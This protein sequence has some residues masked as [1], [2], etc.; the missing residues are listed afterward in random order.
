MVPNRCWTGAEME[1]NSADVA[2]GLD[3]LKSGVEA[4]ASAYKMVRD[5]KASCKQSPEQDKLVDAAIDEAGKAAKIA[6]AQ[7]AKAL[8]YELCRCEFPPHAMLT[9]GYRSMG[10]RT[11]AIYECTRCG[12]NTSGRYNF[13]RN[14]LAP[15]R[16]MAP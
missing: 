1:V 14:P 2:Q 13:V 9:V 15:K 7:I 11:K 4:V 12:I 5:Y 6:E 10:G 8:G 16:T 3:A